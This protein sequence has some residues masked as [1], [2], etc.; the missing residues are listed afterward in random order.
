LHFNEG[1]RERANRCRAEF[2]LRRRAARVMRNRA[3]GGTAMLAMMTCL[4][5][6]GT[7]DVRAADARDFFKGKTVTLVVGDDAGGQYTVNGRLLAQYIGKYIPG[8]PTIIVQN[9]PGASSVTATNYLFAVAPQDGTVFGLPNQSVVLY[10]AAHLPNLRYKAEEMNW[11]GSMTS[12]NHVVAVMARS[13]VET[14][15]DAKKKEVTMGSLGVNGSLSVYP[16]VLNRVAG[17][18]FKVVVGYSGA[19]LVDLAMQRGEI[20]GRGSYTWT[21]LKTSH[22][23]WLATNKIN[24]LA[25]I[26]P[27]KAADLPKVPLLTDLARSQHERQVLTFI[28]SDTVLG[29]PFVLPPHVPAER[30]QILRTAF[31]RAVADPDFLRDAKSMGINIAPVSGAELQKRVEQTV[32]TP[33]EIISDAEKLMTAN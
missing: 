30:V 1:N 25:Q 27:E 9:M 20:D 24:L 32:A 3:R 2:G 19:N 22:P 4:V 28:S 33:P 6:V 13:G 29:R 5:A 14:L 8:E 10:Q 23:D 12:S 7:R 11:I 18:R 17:T 16:T 26:G 21:D 15:D 31:A